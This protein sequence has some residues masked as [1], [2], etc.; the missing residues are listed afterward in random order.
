MGCGVGWGSPHSYSVRGHCIANVMT[1]PWYTC[2]DCG[3]SDNAMV[4]L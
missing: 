1:M 3:V 4:Y 2:S